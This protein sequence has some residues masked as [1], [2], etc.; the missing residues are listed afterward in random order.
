MIDWQTID[1]HLL[2]HTMTKYWRL[3]KQKDQIHKMHH[4]KQEPTK[5][6][7]ACATSA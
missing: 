4:Q 1:W 7:S 3:I 2:T 5:L 6:K